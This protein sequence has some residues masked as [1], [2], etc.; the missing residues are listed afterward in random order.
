[1]TITF[2]IRRALAACAAAAFALA[3]ATADAQQP[4]RVALVVGNTLYPVSPIRN[5]VN[6]ARD[7]AAALRELGFRTIVREDASRADMVAALQEFGKASD[8]A[9]TALFFYAGYATQI[10]DHNYLIPIDAAMAP[11]DDATLFLVDAS[12]VLERMIQ[13]KTRFNFLILDACRESP[14]KDAF[15][16]AAKGLAQMSA[17][18]GTLIAY[19][20]APG[21]TAADGSGMNGLYA[22]HFLQNLRIPDLPAESLFKRVRDGVER[23]S[24]LAQTP[25]NISTTAD[26]FVFNAT[27]RGTTSTA[28]L[29][30]P[31][32]GLSADAAAGLEREFWI[33]ARDSNRAE[34]IQAYIDQYP[35]GVFVVLAKNRLAALLASSRVATAA[36]RPSSQQATPAPGVESPAVPMPSVP[37]TNMQVAP[38]PAASPRST[39]VE[40][41]A[42]AGLPGGGTASAAREIT[43]ADGSVYRGTVRGGQRDGTGEYVSKSNRYQGEWKD[44]LMHGQGVYNWDNGD[45]YEGEFASDLPHGRGKYQFANGDTYAGDVKSGVVV[46]NGTYISK[47]GVRFDGFFAGGKPN[48]TGVYRYPSGDRYEGEV[49][50]GNLHGKGR[51]FQKDGGRIEAPFMDGLAQGRGAAY[52]FNGDRYEGDIRRGHLTGQGTYFYANGLKYEGQVLNALPE[53]QGVLWLVDGSRFEGVFE[54]GLRKAAGLLVNPDGTRTPAK[55]VNRVPMPLN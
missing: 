8:G 3:L 31:G 28:V 46:G 2:L 25:W 50:A 10:K 37:T 21:Q 26:D 41:E 20:A 7:V 16:T 45:R 33:S 12:S 36:P 32:A 47:N 52:F 4:L 9:E 40:A 48:G 14:F 23:D 6:D 51:Y 15:P 53:G 54:N 17:P 5:A 55:I 1:M 43:Y 35:S 13:A 42:N 22:L 24:K 27:G 49:V 29:I 38:R 30:P 34:D 39:G 11:A 18:A 19:A 44:G